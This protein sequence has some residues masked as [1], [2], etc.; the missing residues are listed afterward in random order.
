[1]CARRAGGEE[2]RAYRE[3]SS[4]W[5]RLTS[6]LEGSSFAAPGAGVPM[7]TIRDLVGAIRRRDDVDAESV[8]ALIPS[9]VSAADEFGGQSGRGALTTAI[10][11]HANGVAVVSVLSNDAI[12][13]VLAQPTANLGKLLY[14]LRR[15]RQN[16]AS[17][18]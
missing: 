8:A 18:V 3:S 13:L 6:P 7:P 10:L 4:D 17:L 16:I 12:L 15:N 5:R 9:I 2:Y 1:M 11:E 14:E